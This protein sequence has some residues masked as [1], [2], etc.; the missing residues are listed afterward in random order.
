MYRDGDFDKDEDV[1]STASCFMG[2]KERDRYLPHATPKV[3]LYSSN[4]RIERYNKG[5]KTMGR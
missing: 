2:L 4:F 1:R 3:S 5:C